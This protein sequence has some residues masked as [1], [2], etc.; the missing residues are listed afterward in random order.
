[1]SVFVQ[2]F[3]S[4]KESE[5]KLRMQVQSLQDDGILLQFQLDNRTGRIRELEDHANH[6]KQVVL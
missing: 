6:Y 2:E 4:L 1:M 3:C 5:V